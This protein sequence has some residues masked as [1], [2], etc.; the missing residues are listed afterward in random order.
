VARTIPEETIADIKARAD[1]AGI[2]G[3]TV[4]LKKVGR[5]LV[6]LC[7]FHTEKTPS[8]NVRPDEGFFYCFGCKAA[9]DVVEF[10]VRTTGRGFLDIITE[11]AAQ[12]GVELPK[13]DVDPAEEARQKERKRLLRALELAQV[14]FRTRLQSDEGRAAR[15]Y[16]AEVRKIDDAA[17]DRFGLGFGGSRDD[18]LLTF[19][20]EQGIASADAVAAGVL[21]RSRDEER[22]PYDF[23]RHRITVPIRGQRGEVLSFQGRIF[24]ER[25]TAPDGTKRPKYVNGPQTAVYDKSVVLFGLFE[26]LPGLKQGGA[27]WKGAAVLVEGP[28]DAIAVH[29]AGVPTAVAPCGTS[30]TA[31]HVDEIR[32]RT[33]RIIICLDADAAGKS[34]AARAIVMLLAA[35]MDVGLVGLPDK[36]PDALARDGRLEELRALVV[37]APSA[38][39]ALIARAR[40]KATGNMRARVEALDELLPFLAAPPRELLRAEAIKA[41][42][43]AFNEDERVIA[44]EV[45]KRGRRLVQEALRTARGDLARPGPTRAPAGA[46][47]APAGSRDA[48][49][50]QRAFRAA[51]SPPAVPARLKKPARPFSEP[52]V[53]LVEALLTHP[54]LA[55]RCG[56]L[57]PALRNPELK[58]FI[59]R[60]IE[61]LVRFHDED[62]RAVLARVA[63][64]PD[65]QIRGVLL[66]V[67]QA[68]GFARPDTYL[69]EAAAARIVEDAILTL[70]RK[71]LEVRLGEL[72]GLLAAADER[73]D[74]GERKRI[75]QE[76]AALV[77]ALKALQAP[78]TGAGPRAG[79][80]L[81]L[82]A[83]RPPG[84]LATAPSTPPEPGAARAAAPDEPDGAKAADGAGAPA[85]PDGAGGPDVPGGPTQ[86]APPPEPPWSGEPDDD[87]WA[88]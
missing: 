49:E 80:P 62:P 15:A 34:A 60:L 39:D 76:Q 70:D 32:R 2:I 85:G 64:R 22:P 88:A 3:R 29:R 30:L 75:L 66:K 11:L 52:E 8:F 9:G 82:K 81:A 54:H 18:G 1:L 55:A 4:K 19:L 74:H 13:V 33:E 12:T 58:R 67:T 68:G 25:E 31:R 51:P 44:A 72:Q 87:P 83:P 36:D 77:D 65:G 10:L 43:R 14:F 16:L 57:V 24:G 37:G 40:E 21:A 73:S 7:P 5:N 20:K 17:I 38:L 6:G 86:P 23:F 69:P 78:P 63:V 41:T 45:E 27:P 28:L 84:P 35:G 71:V 61:L 46:P 56:V 48:E 79:A 59:E 47:V 53:M 42:A 26:A 50:G